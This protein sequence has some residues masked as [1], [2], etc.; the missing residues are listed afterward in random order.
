MHDDAVI[1]HEQ[2]A[3]Q[4]EMHAI[5]LPFRR[6]CRLVEEL[7]HRIACERHVRGDACLAQ[8]AG[9]CDGITVVGDDHDVHTGALV[10]A[11]ESFDAAKRRSRCAA[12]ARPECDHRRAANKQR[13][14]YAVTAETW[15]VKVLEPRAWRRECGRR[16]VRSPVEWVPDAGQAGGDAEQGKTGQQHEHGDPDS[17]GVRSLWEG[18]GN[19]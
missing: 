16:V 5:L 9:Q 11:P 2:E 1:A 15:Q 14:M 19:S 18:V 10:F 4:G 8:G 7:V 3:G 13:G 17:H 6:A 12:L